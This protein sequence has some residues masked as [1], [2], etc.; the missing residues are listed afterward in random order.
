LTGWDIVYQDNSHKFDLSATY[1]AIQHTEHRRRQDGP[2]PHFFVE[3][4]FKDMRNWIFSFPNEDKFNEF[5]TELANYSSLRNPVELPPV[6]NHYSSFGRPLAGNCPAFDYVL[7]F[8]KS[9]DGWTV[10]DPV[11]DLERMLASVDPAQ[12]IWKIT[13]IN[14]DY[15]ACSSYPS[16]VALPAA[17]PVDSLSVVGEYRDEARFPVLSYIH[18]NLST[19]TRCS[20]PLIGLGNRR[21]D[22]DEMLIRHIFESN[23]NVPIK[24]NKI[25]DAR[26][27]VNAVGN[28]AKGAGYENPAF[29][30]G[31]EVEFL[32]IENI[33]IIRESL[34]RLRKAT[35]NISPS[36]LNWLSKLEATGWI[37]HI[38]SI[39]KGAVR[40]ADLVK[41]RPFSSASLQSWLG[42]NNTVN[43]SFSIDSGSSLSYHTRL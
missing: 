10:Y 22:A 6:A 19:I 5:N 40:V 4:Y 18:V 34:D 33:H 39:L 1:N 17:F 16:V 12:K 37:T 27:F 15:K 43:L 21:C 20:Q 11:Q 7:P 8:D 38:H 29:Y 3:L 31:V 36:E 26:P 25:L 41:K 24:D 9:E 32:G 28:R 2:P 42:S 35:R 30:Q 23:P 13:N 14:S